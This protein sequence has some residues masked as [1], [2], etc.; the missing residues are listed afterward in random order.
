MSGPSGDCSGVFRGVLE[1][2][3][4]VSGCSGPVSQFRDTPRKNNSSLKRK[5]TYAKNKLQV[6]HRVSL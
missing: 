3:G 4:G 5:A 1:C 2:S 6:K